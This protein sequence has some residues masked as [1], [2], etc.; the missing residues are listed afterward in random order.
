MST[1]TTNKLKEYR[2]KK[3]YTQIQVAELM[4]L[5]CEDRISH[6]ERGS[7]MPS[8]KN[9]MKVAKI[10]GVRMEDLLICDL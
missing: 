7:A 8:V 9:L 1:I 4:G 5:H 6:W 3:G 10:Y 2:L